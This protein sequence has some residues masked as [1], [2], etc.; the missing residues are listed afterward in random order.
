MRVGAAIALALLSF[1][2]SLYAEEARVGVAADF[3]GARTELVERSGFELHG[4]RSGADAEARPSRMSSR[5][6]GLSSQR[7]NR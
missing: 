2:P 3:A 6:R 4:A 1:A 5:E 7:L